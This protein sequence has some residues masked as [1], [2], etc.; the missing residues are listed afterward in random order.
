[1]YTPGT[2]Q[3]LYFNEV[4]SKRK[5]KIAKS[6]LRARSKADKF[7]KKHPTCSVS[8]TLI[9]YNSRKVNDKWGT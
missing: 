7:L 5:T 1:M 6:Y 3:I 8:I 2:Y 4:G 9:M